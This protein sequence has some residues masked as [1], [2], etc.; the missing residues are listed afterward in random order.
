MN[1]PDSAAGIDGV[2]FAA[3]R[4]MPVITHIQV[5]LFIA[6][7]VQVPYHSFSGTPPR[8]QLMRWILKKV[9]AYDPEGRR[10][11]GVPLSFLELSMRFYC[12][13]LRMAVELIEYR[14]G[15]W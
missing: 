14:S 9:F 3:W 1:T 2:P 12:A 15:P 11:L 13:Y 6:Q 8:V 7:I 4:A 5:Y 10:P